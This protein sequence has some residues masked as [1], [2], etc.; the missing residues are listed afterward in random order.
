MSTADVPIRTFRVGWFR[1]T[2]G[3]ILLCLVA[4]VT[5][6]VAVLAVATPGGDTGS[7]AGVPL[8][9]A[10]LTV[11]ILAAAAGVHL[12]LDRRVVVTPT[13]L[14][15]DGPLRRSR[16]TPLKEIARAPI[17]E[18]RDRYGRRYAAAILL[19]DA[20]GA[21]IEMIRLRIP[22]RRMAELQAALGHERDGAIPFPGRRFIRN[23]SDLGLIGGQ[24]GG[25][26]EAKAGPGDGWKRP[27]T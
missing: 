2:V 12:L 9:F 4:L 3:P 22:S 16:A 8:Y 25:G 19:L 1:R 14:R 11:L 13:E 24:D 6:G 5:A 26:W 20:D 27:R 21:P 7:N 23:R 15:I 17:C 18:V 10:A